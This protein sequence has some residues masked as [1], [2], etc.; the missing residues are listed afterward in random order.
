MRRKRNRM[1]RGATVRS[2]FAEQYPVRL[3]FQ[4]RLG[5]ALLER[6]KVYGKEMTPT[7][8]PSHHNQELEERWVVFTLPRAL[9]SKLTHPSCIREGKSHQVLGL[10]MT[11]ST[12]D[13]SGFVKGL[14]GIWAAA[15][16]NEQ[17]RDRMP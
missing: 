11:E 7:Q 5:H 10:E 15:V 16:A 14:V 6:I 9:R 3:L 12:C 1:Q 2:S 4:Q 17:R 8:T 13:A